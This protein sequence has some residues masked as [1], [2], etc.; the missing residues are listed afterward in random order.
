MGR[1]AKN[2]AGQRGATFVSPAT[3][4]SAV[5]ALTSFVDSAAEGEIGIFLA[6]GTLKTTAL[7]AGDQFI[8]A[9]KRDGAIHKTPLLNFNDITSKRKTLY[10][11]PIRKVM[12]VGY[13]LTI[14]TGLAFNFA[15]VSSTATQNVGISIRDTS[16]GNQP[17]PVQEAYYTVQSSTTLF[18]TVAAS[19]VTQLN[20]ERDYEKVAPDTFVVAEIL[21]NGTKTNLT[22]TTSVINGSTAVSSTAHGLSAGAF[23]LFRNVLYKVASATTNALVLDRPYQG[24]TETIATGANNASVAYTDGTNLLGIRLTGL[25]DEVSFLVTVQDGLA[26]AIVGTTAN[27]LQGSGSGITIQD[28]EKEGI[29]FAGIGSTANV[30]F[31]ADYGYPSLFASAAGTYDLFFVDTTPSITPSAAPPVQST[32]QIMHITIAAPTSGTSPTTQLQTVLGV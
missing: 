2:L 15:G 16:P 14:A 4:Y 8:I 10:T 27:W 5:A 29:Y 1:Y 25:R 3:A 19:L 18:Y 12:T 7:A 20:A 9:Q 21:A 23:V 28:L 30:A 32:K 17:F 26:N 6:A 11:A 24:V 13:D 31:S 22:N